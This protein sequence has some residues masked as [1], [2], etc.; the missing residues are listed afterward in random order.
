MAKPKAGGHKPSRAAAC[1]DRHNPRWPKPG[2]GAGEP[3]QAKLRMGEGDPSVAQLGTGMAKTRPGRARP[4]ADELEP[5]RPKL[6]G[7]VAASELADSGTE[8]E[9]PRQVELRIKGAGPEAEK[10]T[11]GKDKPS[12][13]LWVAETA[14]P[15]RAMFRKN[16]V[17]LERANSEAGAK[18][19]GRPRDCDDIVGPSWE[20][21]GTKAQGPEW[22]QD[23][24]GMT[25]PVWL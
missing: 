15:R 2:A 3:R 19:A 6:C 16:K 11:V 20:R 14:K 9:R 12:C 1:R 18:G 10:S 8:V 21:P 5:R 24:K 7:D 25:D 23:L 13:T 4:K 17:K 22:A